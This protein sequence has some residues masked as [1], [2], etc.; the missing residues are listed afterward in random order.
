MFRVFR[1]TSA[2]ILWTGLRENNDFA[3]KK[4][5]KIRFIMLSPAYS[6][7]LLPRALEIEYVFIFFSHRLDGFSPPE[8][9]KFLKPL[10]HVA[11][12][13]DRLDDTLLKYFQ[14]MDNINHVQ[15]FNHSFFSL[16]IYYNYKMWSRSSHKSKEAYQ[17]FD[18]YEVVCQVFLGHSWFSLAKTLMAHHWN[19]C[20]A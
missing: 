20:I 10:K 2:I 4:M 12:E 7:T 18:C 9:K 8:M 1:L 16:S 14:T 11:F 17:M 15:V 13:C 5:C 19:N 6:I 3:G